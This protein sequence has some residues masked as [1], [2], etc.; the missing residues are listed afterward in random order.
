M[1]R[2]NGAVIAFEAG[3]S[4]EQTAVWC[5]HVDDG[6]S[7][8]EI[9]VRL[10]IT[11]TAVEVRMCRAR[12]KVLQAIREHAEQEALKEAAASLRKKLG[13]PHLTGEEPP[14]DNLSAG[15]KQGPKV[16]LNHPH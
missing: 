9:A 13:L 6:L 12:K 3:L 2:Q 14:A 5:L 11:E 4:P 10:G 15:K 1:T 16:S 8:P 7:Y